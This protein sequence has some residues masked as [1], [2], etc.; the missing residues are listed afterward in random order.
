MTSKERIIKALHHIPPDRPP[1]FV[2]VTP[3]IGDCLNSYLGIKKNG[4]VDSFFAN[5]I[6]YTEALTELGNDCVCV[7][8]CWPEGFCVSQ[9]NNG[10]ITDEWGIKWE[11]TGIYSEMVGHPLA[12]VETI[13]DLDSYKFPEALA[14][15]RFDFAEKQIKSYGNQYA[16]IGEQECTI[17]ELSWYLV[18]LEKFLL[19]M[20]MERSY[21]PELLDRVMEINLKQACRLVEMGVD[22]IWTGDDMGNQDG[23][24]I[25]PD[26]W[27]TVFKPRM[28]HVFSTLKRINPEIKIAYHS[29][30]S[31]RPIIPDL[32]EI[33]LDILNPV[34]PLAKNMEALPLK[35]EFGRN[36]S[37]FGGIDIQQLLPHGSPVEIREYV[38]KKKR[39]FGKNGGYIVAPAHNIQPDTPLENILTFF[40][41]AKEI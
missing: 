1:I 25:S 14:K 16:I 19:D 37:F 21:V 38:R 4:L 31:I 29:C 35:V 15:G 30:G 17:F 11:N 2:S 34:Q 7:A 27:R 20:M 10:L 33:G 8:V 23:M 32:I 41:A 36:L 18:G 26:L 24:L 39:I 3:Q 22:I 40:E 6:S 12:E 28:Q 13:D 5:R 9:S